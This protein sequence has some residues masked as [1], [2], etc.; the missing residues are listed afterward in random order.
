MTS[1]PI[2]ETSSPDPRDQL[3]SLTGEQQ[4]FARVVGHALA[5]AWRRRWRKATDQPDSQTQQ[6]AQPPQRTL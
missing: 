4:V 2:H 6:D 3:D 5:E 1:D